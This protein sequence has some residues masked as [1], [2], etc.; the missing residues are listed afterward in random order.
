MDPLPPTSWLTF[1]NA[2]SKNLLIGNEFLVLLSIVSLA[3]IHGIS[4]RVD[5]CRYARCTLSGITLPAWKEVWMRRRDIWRRFIFWRW[6]HWW[7]RYV[8]WTF[9]Y[10]SGVVF[11][12]AE[13]GK[14]TFCCRWWWW[15]FPA[16]SLSLSLSWFLMIV[17]LKTICA[18]L[19]HTFFFF[20]RPYNCPQTMPPLPTPAPSPFSPPFANADGRWIYCCRNSWTL[21]SYWLKIK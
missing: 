8:W 12:K 21:W 14:S 7:K 20:V 17:Y 3:D 1:S 15:F 5:W 16:L 10:L 13:K 4:T 11:V 19:F 18:C 2:Q 9:V 6:E